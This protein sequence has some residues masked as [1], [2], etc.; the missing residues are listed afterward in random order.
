MLQA[1]R[2][3][4]CSVQECTGDRYARGMCS[5][6]YNNWYRNGNPITHRVSL[7]GVAPEVR[8]HKHAMPEPNSG[9]WLWVGPI[10]YAGYAVMEVN[11]RQ[12]R[13]ARFA[14]EMFKGKIP[15]GLTID[16]LCRVRCCVN[17]DHLEAV[18]IRVNIL[19]GENPPAKNG[20]KT[21]CNQGHPLSGEN[22]Y[23]APSGK[24]FCRICRRTRWA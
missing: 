17:P 13:G 11:G 5:R 4:G 16:H 1:H 18:P 12:V 3:I 21:H 9:C 7:A 2:Q 24:R 10:N 22:L 14:F 15:D 8:F 6:H 23:I 19:R 20:R